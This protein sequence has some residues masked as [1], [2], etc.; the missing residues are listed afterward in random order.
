M[1]IE[2]D[3][4]Y[5]V[6]KA[7][8]EE[9]GIDPNTVNPNKVNIYGNTGDQLPIDNSVF[10]HDDLVVNPTFFNGNTDSDWDNGEYL[11]F[12]GDGANSWEF[13]PSDSGMD[14]NLESTPTLT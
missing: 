2:S 4:I 6:D 12:Y 10:R 5:R 3:G 1:K 11:L 8:L 13:D 14:F 7:F 9:N